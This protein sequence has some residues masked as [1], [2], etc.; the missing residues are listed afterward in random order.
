MQVI[1]SQM[2]LSSPTPSFILRANPILTSAF[3]L[4]KFEIMKFRESQRLDLFLG[5]EAVKIKQS[6]YLYLVY[7]RIFFL[8]VDT[9]PVYIY[10]IYR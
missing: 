10:Y 5:Q 3:I 8:F 2:H 7:L 1:Q 9:L 6:A 4:L